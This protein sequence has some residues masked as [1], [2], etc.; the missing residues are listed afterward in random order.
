MGIQDSISNQHAIWITKRDNIVQDLLNPAIRQAT[1]LD[2]LVAYFTSGG[3]KEIAGGLST[4]IKQT[5]GPL[6]LIISPILT[7]EDLEFIEARKNESSNE[8]IRMKAREALLGNEQEIEEGLIKYTRACLAELIRQGRIEMKAAFLKEGDYH[9][10][11]YIIRSATDSI[12]IVGS[13][14]AT[15]KAYINNSETLS[16]YYSWTGPESIKAIQKI[17]EY[18][19]DVWENK[20]PDST[21]I[22]I[23]EA[24]KEEMIQ[25]YP[26]STFTDSISDRASTENS[27]R[28]NN[29][30]KEIRIPDYINY[31]TGDY[32]HQ[33]DAVNAWI[34]SNYRGILAMATGSG[35]TKTSLIAAALIWE[36]L[37]TKLLVIVTPTTLLVDQ[38]AK[39][40]EAFNLIPITSQERKT[41]QKI[42][43]ELGYLLKNS[44]NLEC[45]ICTYHFL[46]NESTS[47]LLNSIKSNLMVIFD[48]CHN[49]NSNTARFIPSD[50]PFCIGLSAT[51]ERQYDEIGSERITEIIGETCFEFSLKDAIGKSL[52]RYTYHPHIVTLN[53][54]ESRE[55]ESIT[56]QIIRAAQQED[57]EKLERLLIK[58]RRILDNC[59]AKLTYWFDQMEAQKWE[60]YTLVYTSDKSTEQHTRV[61]EYMYDNNVDFSQ[62][63]CEE[64]SRKKDVERIINNFRSRAIKV[65][66]AKRVLDEGF[67]I[68]EITNAYILA[69]TTVH[70]Q[71]IQRMGRL[72]RKSDKLPNKIASIHDYIVLPNLEIQT[73]STVKQII[74]SELK[75]CYAF[76]EFSE[77]GWSEDGGISLVSELAS[78]YGISMED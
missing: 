25:R 20:L 50:I 55:Y 26:E 18:F 49:I 22:D 43:L 39:E 32:S 48:E 17:S 52:T 58:R 1:S 35:K 24:I 42:I 38:W 5:E 9:N 11:D 30:K 65:I 31:K 15:H 46:R 54:D 74:K 13:A 6:R 77:N 8:L 41:Q 75:R 47:R 71:W 63:T 70:R 66:C 76:S 23:D 51:P 69:S 78:R 16:C 28:A 56:K 72:L 19:D 62:L 60:A 7:K 14:N 57:Q 53:E 29:N 37:R 68:P 3:L 40:A 10:K 34:R 2:I 33:N 12:A 27:N 64:T 67:D 36:K 59:K 44:N 73:S 45:L 4:F 61:C 21:T